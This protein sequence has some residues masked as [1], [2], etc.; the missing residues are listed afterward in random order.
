[1]TAHRRGSLTAFA[2][3][4]LLAACGEPAGPD[5]LLV[6]SAPYP[7]AKPAPSGAPLQVRTEYALEVVNEQI[8]REHV[9]ITAYF[10]ADPVDPESGLPTEHIR[11]NFAKTEA[12]YTPNDK[13]GSVDGSI[14]AAWTPRRRGG[15]YEFEATGP[16]AVLDAVKVQV[17]EEGQAVADLTGYIGGASGKLLFNPKFKVWELRLAL[18]TVDLPSGIVTPTMLKTFSGSA[19][20][21]VHIDQTEL[22]TRVRNNEFATASPALVL[23]AETKIEDAGSGQLQEH[24]EVK[25]SFVSSEL[26]PFA[27]VDVP[28]MFEFEINYAGIVGPPCLQI[29]IPAGAWAQGDGGGFKLEAPDPKVAGITFLVVEDGQVVNDLSDLI[30]GIS[31]ILHYDIATKS[32]RLGLELAGIP[33]ASDAPVL[34]PLAGARTA[35]LDIGHGLEVFSA[36]LRSNEGV[37]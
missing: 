15:G 10:S 36:L 35:T 1:M 29:G 24:F 34:A 12:S 9:E 6:W 33:I 31:G 30:D 2:L 22:T 5:T 3:A 17:I 13:K 4:G 32:W 25:T 23:S 19:V 11:F 8:V 27:T 14:D 28:L 7:Q 16:Q 37:F 21:T 26:T 18:T 20:A